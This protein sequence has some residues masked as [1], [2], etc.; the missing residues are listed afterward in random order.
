MERLGVRG[1]WFMVMGLIFGLMIWWAPAGLADEVK[2]PEAKA[3]E[4]KG[5]EMPT[6]NVRTDILS[7]YVWRGIALS[8]NSVVMQ[9]SIT[10]TYKGIAFN[11]VE[12]LRHAGA[13][14]LWP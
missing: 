1:K 11:V 10:G 2:K 3:E 7:Q 4:A 6:W 5:P 14:P 13:K 9:P 8:R 12:Q